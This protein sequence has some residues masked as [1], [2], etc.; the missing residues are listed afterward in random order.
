VTGIA[1]GLVAAIFIGLWFSTTRGISVL[2]VAILT[3]AHPWLAV[4]I[5]IGSAAAFYRF[6]FRK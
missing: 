2:A 3:A 5:V 4:P 1:A 6:H